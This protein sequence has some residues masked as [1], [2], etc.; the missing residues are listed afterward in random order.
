MEYEFDKDELMEKIKS[1]LLPEIS[2]ISFN[3][4]IN[5]LKIESISENNIVFVCKGIFIKKK[6]QKMINF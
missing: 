2:P 6:I 5:P 1:L 4:Y 3:T